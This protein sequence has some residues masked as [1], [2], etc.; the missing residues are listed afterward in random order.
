MSESAP[1]QGEICKTYGP[2]AIEYLVREKNKYMR[3]LASVQSLI[4]N[5]EE[6]FRDNKKLGRKEFEYMK[7]NNKWV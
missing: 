3:E 4:R 5:M 2:S 1:V 6:W 7:E